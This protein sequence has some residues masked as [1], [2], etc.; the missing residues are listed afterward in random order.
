MTHYDAII[1]GAGAMGSAT[2]YHMGKAGQRVLLLEQ[3]ELKHER[4]SSQDHTRIIRYA[5]ARSNYIDLAKASYPLWFDLEKMSGET[6]YKRTG[7]LDFGLPVQTDV[8]RQNLA[9]KGIAHEVIDPADV[10]KRFPQFRIPSTMEVIYQPDY[11]ILAAAKA[12]ATHIRLAQDLYGVE[13]RANTPVTALTPSGDHVTVTTPAGTFEAG[14][15]ILTAGAWASDLLASI[16]IT[17]PLKPMQVQ[18]AYFNAGEAYNAD[19]LPIFI[20]WI[21]EFAPYGIPDWQ[22][23]GLKLALHGGKLVDHISQVDYTPTEAGVEVIRTFC[24]TYLP[25]AAD[26]LKNTRICLYTM[27]PDEDFVIDRHP[28]Y[29]NILYASPCS[30]HGFKFSALIGQIMTDLALKGTTEHDLSLFRANR[31]LPA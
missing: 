4:G 8:I 12:V 19:N 14:R 30:G 21:D 7:G 26:H 27:T 18:L 31:F 1:I 24:K 23:S 5:Y 10:Q 17:L 22:G 28:E 13:V 3:F 20:A 25:G 2:A 11:G 16:G 15:V 29:E 9:D 6:L